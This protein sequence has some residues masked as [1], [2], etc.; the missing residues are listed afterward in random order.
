MPSYMSLCSPFGM[1]FPLDL[2][3]TFSF[4][5]PTHYHLCSKIKTKCLDGQEWTEL[6]I[7]L[8][9]RIRVLLIRY[10]NCWGV[11]FLPS[12]EPEPRP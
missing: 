10:S 2:A 3:R 12:P 8:I 5:L 7:F 9:D 6:Y 1:S 11:L 4:F